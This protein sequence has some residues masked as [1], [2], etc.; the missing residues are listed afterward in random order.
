MRKPAFASLVIV[1]LFMEMFA[2][3]AYADTAPI[4]PAAAPAAAGTQTANPQ[5][6]ATG[7]AAPATSA[8]TTTTAST[9]SS[10]TAAPGTTTAASSSTSTTPQTTSVGG[11]EI[12]AMSTAEREQLRNFLFSSNGA[13]Q[14]DY[15][16]DLPLLDSLSQS[17]KPTDPFSKERAKAPTDLDKVVTIQDV[18]AMT[19]LKEEQIAKDL[20]KWDYDKGKVKEGATVTVPELKRMAEQAAKSNPDSPYKLVLN[21]V[22]AFLKEQAS[23]G[24]KD[25]ADAAQAKQY[26]PYERY[27]ISMPGS[28]KQV[29]LAEIFRSDKIDPSSCLLKDEIIN[30]R[31]G[32]ISV[33]DADLTYGTKNSQILKGEYKSP[34]TGKPTPELASS[35]SETPVNQYL[36]GKKVVSYLNL[37]GGANLVVPEFYRDWI[38]FTHA[39][40][41]YDLYASGVLSLAALG[42]VKELQ[43]IQKIKQASYDRT[44]Q[45]AHHPDAMLSN[46]IRETIYGAIER[47]NLGRFVLKEPK[48]VPGSANPLGGAPPLLGGTAHSVSIDDVGGART[49]Q[50]FDSAGNP[51]RAAPNINSIE[52][53]VKYDS[54]LNFKRSGGLEVD[55]K[56][57]DL[58]IKRMK[59]I[60]K[61]FESRVIASY[62]IAGGWLGPARMAFMIDS[63][64]LFQARHQKDDKFLRVLAN[65]PV[66]QDFK[67]AS[68]IL[69]LGKVQETVAK[70]AGLGFTPEKAFTAKKLLLID[71]P[72]QQKVLNS[73]STTSFKESDDAL[74]GVIIRPVWTG[75]SY[76]LN[77]EDVRNFGS[78]G[79]DQGKE[80]FTSM[81]IVSNNILL[82]PS[83][84][85]RNLK[86][87]TALFSLAVPFFVTRKLFELQE[88]ALGI[89]VFATTLEFLNINENHGKEVACDQKEY[90]EFK[91]TYRMAFGA[92]LGVS[93]LTLSRSII[94]GFRTFLQ[95]TGIATTAINGMMNVLDWTNPGDAWRFHVGNQGITYTSNCKDTM[96]TILTY[97]S[98]P[99]KVAKV[100]NVLE[101]KLPA[102]NDQLK[103]IG[104]TKVI[105]ADEEEK[106]AAEAVKKLTEILNLRTVLSDQRGVVITPELLYMHAQDST[107]SVKGGLYGLIRDGC[108]LPDRV[109]AKDGR[110]LTFSDGLEA[111]NADG[112]KALSFKSEMWKLRAMARNR[113][114]ALARIIIPNKIIT[115]K[116]TAGNT[117]V[118]LEVASSGQSTL[119]NPPCDLKEAIKKVTGRDIGSDFTQA[120]GKV[121]RVETTEGTATILDKEIDFV[122]NNGFGAS[123]PTPE[124]IRNAITEGASLSILGNGQVTMRGPKAGGGEK[125]Q[126]GTLV[127]V[128]GDNGALHYDAVT[129]KLAL[130]IYSIFET[131][132][133]NIQDYAIAPKGQGIQLEAKA[134]RGFEESA[135]KLNEALKT[136]T[137]DEGIKSFETK[138]HIYYITP[139]GKLRV[140]D[141]K[142]GQ[143]KDYN[144]TG[145][146]RQDGNEVIIP[147]DKGDFKFSV[148][149][150]NGQPTLKAEGP[151]GLKE[152]LALLAA[153]GQDGILTFNPSTGAINVYNGQDVPLNPSFAEKGIGFSG[154]PDGS[155]QGL[156]ADNPFLS[157]TTSSTSTSSTPK[158][159]LP[160]WPEQALPAMLMFLLVAL[161]VLYIRFRQ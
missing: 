96:H 4:A 83:L 77:Y 64:I 93:L 20:K 106:K 134:K 52:E 27:K 43:Q 87:L 13:F 12:S 116:L 47:N 82:E 118:F 161:G 38:V 79:K 92:S 90:E 157:P 5:A 72:E 115:S 32:F 99:Q 61:T 124:Q 30:G 2:P 103:K 39:Y 110:S 46:E 146:I 84:E 29:S 58:N 63:G 159:F 70:Y 101:D 105:G 133:Q 54:T 112:T 88:S 7:P 130:I 42:G 69:A 3:F 117:N 78:F 76:T 59:E 53:A 19:G 18:S 109:Q 51:I 22:Q 126:L 160:S 151:D 142:T 1:L 107:F 86:S 149:N 121:R 8:T 40:T 55:I 131:S 23:T 28:G 120:I 155:S 91:N 35:R 140:I 37:N 97:Q 94:P 73:G 104:L 141:K 14:G 123:A 147:T 16:N 98:I 132:A 135:N 34:A 152:V 31:V 143:A 113:I 75:N 62:M 48:H 56:E 17:E 60:K 65:K 125:Q 67:K 57:A 154:N 85:D 138:D 25:K 139:D 128:L 71:Y 122:G 24:E 66:L 33:L 45:L 144:I 49:L 68:G 114:Q 26:E 136:I 36:Y 50:Y 119:V 153:R 21:E 148:N 89:G 127:T 111:F 145:P 11:C 15:L 10:T 44:V 100:N 81:A 6:T 9:A 129:G 108:A 74:G 158:L 137:G 95:G 102:L 156:P 150:D 41:R 80:D